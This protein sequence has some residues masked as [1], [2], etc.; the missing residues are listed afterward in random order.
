M[1][2]NPNTFGLFIMLTLFLTWIARIYFNKKTNIAFY[3]I[4]FASLWFTMSRS[5]LII[6]GVISIAFII[7]L[8]YNKQIKLL[9]KTILKSAAIVLAVVIALH[10]GVNWATTQYYR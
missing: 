8:I 5:S 4:L 3:C 10:F 6:A 1:F 2:Y 9:Y 7:F